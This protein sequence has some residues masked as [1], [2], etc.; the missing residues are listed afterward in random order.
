MAIASLFNASIKFIVNVKVEALSW[1]PKQ[2][3]VNSEVEVY[4]SEDIKS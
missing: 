3:E 4:R 1:L 2:I